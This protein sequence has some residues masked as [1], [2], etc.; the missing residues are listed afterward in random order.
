M[1]KKKIIIDCDPGHD[2]AIALLL[3]ACSP[4]IKLLGVSVSSGNQTIEKTSRNA[5]NICRYF[6]INVPIAIGCSHPLVSEPM[7]CEEVHGKSGLDGFDFPKYEVKFDTRNGSS[8]I[9]D[10]LSNNEDVTV[11]TTGPMTNLALALRLKPQIAQHIKEIIFMG[12]SVD[13]GNVSPAAEFNILVDA[14]AAHIVMHSGVPIKMI[15]L[16]VT[17]KVL[18]TDEIINRAFAIG[19]K[20]SIF[21]AKLMR[22]F[23]DNQRKTF[24]IDGAPL[25]DPVTVASLI[26]DSLVNFQNM[27]VEIDISHSTSHGRTN[28]DVFDYLDAPKNCLVGMDIVVKRFW[29][30]IFNC[31]RSKYHE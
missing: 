31:L 4:K 17:R 19:N 25:H 6:D 11:V 28:C 3:A 21:F 14:E 5:L 26:D 9:A 16:N 2:D 22:V 27:N 10:L 7:I 12:G 15:G 23:L 29:K 8:L 30:L 20:K 1:E 13:N 24:H 18:V